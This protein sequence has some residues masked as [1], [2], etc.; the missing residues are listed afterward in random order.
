[1]LALFAVV[2]LVPLVLL[3]G[4]AVWIAILGG[5][6]T[7]SLLERLYERT[8]LG[9]LINGL[10]AFTLAAF[11]VF[12]L[13]LH[14]L[15]IASITLA[16]LL[17][18]WRRGNLRAVSLPFGI[19]AYGGVPLRKQ[20]GTVVE[21]PWEML[22]FLVVAAVFVAL[23][24]RPFEV[25]LGVR[26]AGI[27]ATTGFAIARTGG[28][29]QYDEVV[30]QI[31]QEAKAPRRGQTETV[32]QQA[33]RE[34]AEQAQ[35]N[36]LAP[37]SDE[38]A[39]ATKQ[40][41][42]GYYINDGDITK[43]RVVPQF[44]H[45]FPA[46]IAL[47][48][49]MLGLRG[50][51]LATGVLGFLGVWSVG[52]LGRALAGRW[53]G[54]LG[55][56][57]LAL[58]GVQV[59]FSRYSTAEACAQF[60]IFAGLYGFALMHG[61]PLGSQHEPRRRVFGAMLAGIAFGQLPLARL[62]FLLVLPPLIGY[63]FYRGVSRRWGPAQTVFGAVLAVMLLGASAYILLIA[64]AYVLDTLFARLQ[65]QSILVAALVMPFLT[66]QLRRVYVTTSRS[67]FKQP[68]RLLVELGA[69][70]VLIFGSVWLRRDGRV[71]RWAEAQAVRWRRWV[72]GGAVALVVFI[73][74]Y[75][76]LIR[77]QIL[78]PQVL[79]SLPSCVTPAQLRQPS[80]G[81]LTLQGYVGAPIAPP[82]GQALDKYTIPLSNFVRFG[83]Y[84]SPLGVV[85]G[86]AGLALWLWR[87]LN[88]ASWLFL[89]LGL[90]TT[91][92]F[93]RQSYGTDEQTYIYILRRFVPLVYPAFSLGMAYALVA[94]ARWRPRW[95]VGGQ[96]SAGL[97]LVAML[98]FLGVTNRSIYRHV[99]YAGLVDQLGMIASRFQPDAILLFRGGDHTAAASRDRADL[100]ATPLTYGFGLQAF[101]IKSE[102]PDRYAEPLAEYIRHWQS[103]GR[104]VYLVLGASGGLQLPG[105]AQE[106]AG[107]INLAFP[108]YEQ[109]TNQKPANV[110]QT[111]LDYAVYR[112]VPSD[113]A[114]A[115][116]Q[117]AVD[118]FAAQVRGFYRPEQFSGQLRAW[119]DGDALLR[120]PWLTSA[121][122]T[123]VQLQLAAGKRP[124]SLGPAQVCVSFLPEQTYVVDAAATFRNRQC[125]VAQEAPSSYSYELD[126]SGT[127]PP[128]GTMLLRIESAPWIPAETP[129]TPQSNDRRSLGVQFISA[130]FE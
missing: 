39:I 49:S 90:L 4:S 76:Y 75:G 19:T 82:S 124:A 47:L 86:I 81:C 34:A 26:D 68:L 33:L 100:I 98:L 3:P 21:S 72:L 83:W 66:D 44:L 18:A 78:T 125:F 20:L 32:E 12:S 79:A 67:V 103:Q 52:M 127:P 45:L 58:N 16:G 122:S 9:A 46:W 116:T 129:S 27:Y 51:L 7:T 130:G 102:Q 5:V 104:T 115:P 23:V 6:P 24:G 126:L 106:P 109:L 54:V 69:L 70:Q 120:L 71:L 101:A 119:T 99:E 91:L 36:F 48:A 57:L 37:Q 117:V 29:V 53:V 10:T 128:T 31:G 17:V 108:E 87:D 123:T 112:F 110:Q 2:V 96:I 60:L 88:R 64:R 55:A 43:G 74:A 77:P 41:L 50:G 114:S 59:W 61:A 105:L 14:L 73:A 118:D 89:G 25:V 93:V 22:G 8:L 80:G 30:A 113:Q 62:D 38:R 1:M 121:R 40:R 42:A 111:T 35:S 92:F 28:I 65:D 56:L 85:L 11:G 107:R 63:L 13:L 95:R 94:L 15:L 84:L 97:L